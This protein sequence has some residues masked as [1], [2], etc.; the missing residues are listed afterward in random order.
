MRAFSS[1]I[2][3][4]LCAG[5]MKMQEWDKSLGDTDEFIVITYAKDTQ[6]AYREGFL[7]TWEGR[8]QS[9][10]R[11]CTNTSVEKQRSALKEPK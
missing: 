4:V 8:I 5:P 7:G 11:A 6:R 9:R 2:A 1:V 3:Y 10:G